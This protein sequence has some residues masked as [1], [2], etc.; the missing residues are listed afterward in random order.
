MAL[1]FDLIDEIFAKESVHLDRIVELECNS[2][3]WCLTYLNSSLYDNQIEIVEKISDLNCRYI[4]LAGSRSMG[5]S[6]SVAVGLIK[7]CIDN[8]PLLVGI[9]APKFDQASRLVSQCIE[10]L[11]N[12]ILSDKVL[13]DKSTKSRIVFENGSSIISN[14]ASEVS[15]VEGIHVD[16][17]VMDEAHKIS[18]L[19]I[20][21]KLLPMVASSR[22][23]K[24]IKLG[25]ALYKNHFWRSYND[26]QYEHLIYDWTLCPNLLRG[27]SIIVNGKEYS[28]YVIDRMPIQIK[29]T[30]F[31]NNPELW[32]NTSDTTEIDF[33]TQYLIQWIDGLDLLLNEVDQQ[34]LTSGNHCWLNSGLIT[35]TYYAGLDTAG[36]SPNHASGN[37]DFT[38]LSIWRKNGFQ[39]K[40]KVHHVEWRGDVTQAINEIYELINPQTGKFKCSFILVDYSNIGI[41]LVESYKKL[42]VPIEGI[43][44]GS[45]EKTSGK[46]YKNALADQF[47]FELRSDRVKF[48]KDDIDKVKILKKSLN[49]WQSMERHSGLGINDKI[50][51]P[52]GDGL[53]DDAAW[54]DS[55]AVFAADKH[56]NFKAN[57]ISVALEMPLPIGVNSALNPSMNV[58]DKPWWMAN[59]PKYKDR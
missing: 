50:S 38:S 51:V 56:G 5:K 47:L 31:P 46:N 23:G 33:K 14:S 24:I 25:V 58:P 32:I 16:C 7:L 11:K 29:H 26:P 19:S 57:S 41:N 2:S 48:P 59:F 49:E 28:K 42:G 37:L 21:Q 15:N 53:H 6:Y 52:E 22:I 35:D 3:L 30:T 13:W 4:M 55:M 44:F 54:A 39:V 45:T 9:F 20:S 12:S 40:E 18:D 17:L 34:M 10:L 36:G 1:N 8:A 43:T 27:G